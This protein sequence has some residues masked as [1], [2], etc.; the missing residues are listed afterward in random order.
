MVKEKSKENP[1]EQLKYIEYTAFFGSILG[2]LIGI[3]L[4]F[5]INS[6]IIA[7]LIVGISIL[8]YPAVKYIIIPN[9]EQNG[10]QESS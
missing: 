5:S 10:T 7:I 8:D 3:G 4:Y 2:V 9:M 1:Q 6:P